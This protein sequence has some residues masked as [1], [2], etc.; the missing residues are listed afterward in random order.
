MSTGVP[1]AEHRRKLG[2]EVWVIGFACAISYMGI[3]LVDP[4]LPTISRALNAT[5]GQTELLFSTYLFVTAIVMF[6]S[7]WISSRIGQRRTLILGL[8]LVVLFALSCAL[9]G[10]VQWVIGFRGGWGVGNALFV[11]TALAAIIGSAASSVQAIVIYE[12]AVGAGMAFGPL[13]G[14]LLGD[15]SWRGPFLGTAVLMMVA[16]AGIAAV[17]H[18]RRPRNIRRSFSAPFKALIQPEFRIFLLATLFY[19]YAYFTILAYAPFPLY[20]AATANGLYFSPLD[21]G[22]VFFGWGGL[23]A[24]GSVFIAPRLM[25]RFGVHPTIIAVLAVLTALLAVLV[26]LAG[27]LPVQV[28]GTILSGGLVG[29]TN[30]AMTA[31]AMDATAL[32][33]DIASSAYSGVRFIGGAIGPTLA[34][35]I[36]TAWGASAP[37][38]VAT[39]VVVVT[40]ALLAVERLR[41]ASK[42]VWRSRQ[43]DKEADDLSQV[44]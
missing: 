35:P 39:L 37:Y 5:P 40:I 23:L 1:V 18:E 16:L 21:L 36:S 44:A 34:G 33:H 38:G 19:N 43:L 26:A 31:A 7:S 8:S 10:N 2:V 32:P 4:I 22:L 17:F 13:V 30:T 29:A 24:L 6:F 14:G 12:A 41:I 28:V 3:G 15:I 11:S 27:N 25:R 42:S 9:S 20:Y